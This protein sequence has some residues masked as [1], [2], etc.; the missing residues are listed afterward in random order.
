MTFWRRKKPATT[1]L[2][3][4]ESVHAEG[5]LREFVYLDEVSVRSLRASRVGALPS[6]LK[7]MQSAVLAA[8]VS[9]S[10]SASIPTVVKGS[11][12]ATLSSNRSSGVEI[13]RKSIV[14][15]DFKDF[16]D[17]EVSRLKLGPPTAEIPDT[18]SPDVVA[19]ETVGM[20]RAS[21]LERAGVV[22]LTVRIS[23]AGIYQVGAIFDSL[24]TL[25]SGPTAQMDPGAAKSLKDFGPTNDLVKELLAG[26]VPIECES[27]D[28]VVGWIAGEDWVIHRDLLPSL[29]GVSEVRRL[30]IAATTV[31]SL[32]WQDLRQILFAGLEFD[33]MARIMRSG[34][35]PKWSPVK[36]AD[37]FREFSPKTANAIDELDALIKGLMR[38]HAATEQSVTTPGPNE[39]ERRLLVYARA[40]LRTTENPLAS[41]DTISDK[42]AEGIGAI[43][44]VHESATSA[45]DLHPAYDEVSDLLQAAGVEHPLEE[46]VTFRTIANTVAT[47]TA[48]PPSLPDPTPRAFLETEVVAI[49]W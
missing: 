46:R 5:T 18:I 38:G 29:E 34:V 15:S 39:V 21:D 7:D 4:A 48:T 49:Y 2:L 45:S 13:L 3:E 16:R 47:L 28:Y 19:G 31:K 14:Q 6:E 33:V 12:E 9:T 20:R 40:A 32:Y 42:L 22:E 8:E 23:P 44:K 26:L 27:V 11:V 35:S 30:V 1:A 43:A 36:L 41:E 10:A 37:V 25:L 17:G 24:S